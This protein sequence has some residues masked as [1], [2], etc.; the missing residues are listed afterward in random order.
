MCVTR[1]PFASACSERVLS[2]ARDVIAIGSF[3]FPPFG[4]RNVDQLGARVRRIRVAHDDVARL[5]RADKLPDAVGGRD[6]ELVAIALSF[7]GVEC[8]LLDLRIRDHTV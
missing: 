4:F 6:D 1:T 5:L 3:L 2:R 7:C 8:E